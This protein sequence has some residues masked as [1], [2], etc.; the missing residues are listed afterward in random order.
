MGRGGVTIVG[1]PTH[2]VPHN[3]A[4]TIALAAHTTRVRPGRRLHH[5][6]PHTSAPTVPI[7]VRIESLRWSGARRMLCRITLK[8]TISLIDVS[9]RRRLNHAAP[10]NSSSPQDA[11]CDS[12]HCR[13]AYLCICSPRSCPISWHTLRI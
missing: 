11:Y 9:L 7:L 2:A 3:S 8:F 12:T 10:H 13:V 4:V 5:A 1:R 6:V